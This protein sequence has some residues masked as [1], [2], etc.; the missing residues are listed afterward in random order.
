MAVVMAVFIAVCSGLWLAAGLTMGAGETTTLS[1]SSPETFSRLK[2]SPF[3]SIVLPKSERK[4]TVPL[5]ITKDSCIHCSSDGSNSRSGSNSG[6]GSN[7]SSHRDRRNRCSNGSNTSGS[8]CNL[9]IV[10]ASRRHIGGTGNENDSIY[11][12]SLSGETPEHADAIV[13]L[14]P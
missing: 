13:I 5:R 12:I 2:N 11:Y 4:L 14:S 10:L 3:I 8:G 7:R 9:E 1:S 6:S